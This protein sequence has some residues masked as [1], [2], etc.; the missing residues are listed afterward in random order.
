MKIGK[1]DFFINST[2]FGFFVQKW[3]WSTRDIMNQEDLGRMVTWFV[4]LYS[5]GV[6]VRGRAL[7][8]R[9]LVSSTRCSGWHGNSRMPQGAIRKMTDDSE[10]S[11]SDDPCDGYDTWS[12]TSLQTVSPLAV[13]F[14]A[15]GHRGP[16]CP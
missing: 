9:T 11:A 12:A 2:Y 13:S 7:R 16:L 3:V 8:L 10:D 4:L 1:T 15:A 14:K 6:H 5:I